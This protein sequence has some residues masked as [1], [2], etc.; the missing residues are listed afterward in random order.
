MLYPGIVTASEITITP[1]LRFKRTR[2]S[3]GYNVSPL[4]HPPAEY[5]RT[6]CL[7][8]VEDAGHTKFF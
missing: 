6:N 8:F 1:H 2:C 7:K 4:L 3:E 5:F